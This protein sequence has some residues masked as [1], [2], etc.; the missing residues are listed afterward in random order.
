M[1]SISDPQLQLDL[2][3]QRAAELHAEAEAYRIARALSAGRH[4]R[5]WRRS[6]RAHRVRA[7]E[8]PVAS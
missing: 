2:H 7:A 8:T 5:T 6:R 1:F 4:A 3:R